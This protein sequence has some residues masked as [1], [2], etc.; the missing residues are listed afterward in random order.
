MTFQKNLKEAV[1][2]RF[3]GPNYHWWALAVTCLG[4]FMSAYDGGAVGI[5]L[6]RIMTSF[7]TSLTM[8]SWVLLSYL[9]VTSALLLPTGRMGDIWGRK[10]I[11]SLGF[12][13]FFTGSALCG[14]SQNQMQLILFRIFQA[15]GAAMLQ[16]SSFAI[17][18]SV[19]PER[20]R[21]KALG[22]FASMAAVGITSGPAIGGLIVSTL[23]WRSIFFLNVPLGL[24][25]TV[26]AQLILKDETF[27]EKSKKT[28]K[29]FDLPGA[30]ISAVAICGLLIGLTLG[31]Q[32]N[33]FAYETCLSLGTAVAAMVIF[34]WFESRRAYPLVDMALF[35]NRTFSLNMIARF[36]CF[37]GTSCTA[38]LMPFFL[39]IILGFSAFK[40]G[41]LIAPVSLVY[42]IF[43]PISGW[44]A[45]YI[46]TQIL[47]SAGMGLM[48]LAF[49]LLSRL[50]LSSDYP[51]V[52]G[53]FVLLGIGWSIFQTPNN[54][55]IMDSVERNR[56]GITSGILAFVRQTGMALGV[57]LGSTIVVAS[58]FSTV[59]RVSIYSLKQDRG[60]LENTDAL[61]AF[62]AGIGKAF[63]VVCLL[64]ILGGVTTLLIGTTARDRGRHAQSSPPGDE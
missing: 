7:K 60:L 46:R 63:W 61:I 33:W 48:A 17:V 52:L 64:C 56:F 19:F 13:I 25:G 45:N 22:Y 2:N 41:L 43:S 29:H 1:S 36:I 8:V 9:L 30:C 10:K 40:A 62:S 12:A 21:G 58:M 55:S 39:Q 53:R 24:I 4:T 23:G 32:G 15:L 3:H 16:T 49:Y 34:P 18:T 14:L 26:L 37:L 47:S 54:T 44:L 35:K 20:D 6:P 42:G 51:G 27:P 57:A 59:G 50:D 28:L 11:F 31:R 38:L 5:S